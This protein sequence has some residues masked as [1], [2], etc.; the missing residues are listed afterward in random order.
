M[1]VS[2]DNVF[3]IGYTY[4]EDGTYLEGTVQIQRDGTNPS[5][6]VQ[7]P[8]AA[9]QIRRGRYNLEGA[10]QKLRRGGTR[11]DGAARIQWQ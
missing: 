10:V 2:R 7:N 6:A 11:P 4:G 3:V 1:Y 8:D 9:V 5:G